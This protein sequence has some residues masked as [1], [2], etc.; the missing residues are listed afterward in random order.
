MASKARCPMCGRM[1]ALTER[2]NL[3][4]HNNP[5]TDIMCGGTGNPP[6]R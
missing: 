1:I 2:G 6:R 4:P 3:R 5:K